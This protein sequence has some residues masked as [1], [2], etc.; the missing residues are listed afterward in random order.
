M[1]ELFVIEMSGHGVVIIK[2]LLTS[3]LQSEYSDLCDTFVSVW[4]T[5]D[6]SKHGIPI[7]TVL[8]MINVYQG[9]TSNLLKHATHQGKRTIKSAQ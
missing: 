7:N 9:A 1:Y 4:G 6:Y 3:N 8:K 5:L 2:V